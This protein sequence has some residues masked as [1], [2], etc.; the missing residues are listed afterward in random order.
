MTSIKIHAIIVEEERMRSSGII[1]L[2]LD[3]YVEVFTVER[4]FEL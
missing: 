1:P 2:G 4:E 3:R